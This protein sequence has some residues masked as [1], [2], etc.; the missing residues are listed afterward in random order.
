MVPALLYVGHRVI[1][2]V[3]GWFD[4]G[5]GNDPAIIAI[6]SRRAYARV[7]ADF[8]RRIEAARAK[9]GRVREIERQRRET[10]HNALRS[11]PQ[12]RKPSHV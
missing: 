3:T 2:A 10:I 9:H 11:N 1:Q 4:C 8:N 5:T 12:S 7:Q 6:H